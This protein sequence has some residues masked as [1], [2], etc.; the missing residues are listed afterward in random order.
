M[1][2][3]EGSIISG[4]KIK[5]RDEVIKRLKF[6]AKFIPNNSLTDYLFVWH[7]Q[8]YEI[9]EEINQIMAKNN[10]NGK[11][12]RI[13]EAGPVIGTHVG[14]KSL[15]FVYIGNYNENWLTKMKE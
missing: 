3:A 10:N 7:T 13:I 9:A 8:D 12:I 14:P 1:H 5:G 2:F 4:G 15:G 6:A 11:N